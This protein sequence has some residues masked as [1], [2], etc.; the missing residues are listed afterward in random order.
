MD[1][2]LHWWIELEVDEKTCIRTILENSGYYELIRK[3]YNNTNRIRKNKMV[4]EIYRLYSDCYEHY[5]SY[6]TIMDSIE[7]FM[8]KKNCSFEDAVNSN[9]FDIRRF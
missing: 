2:K 5:Y 8:N 7:D 9:E 6:Y 3:E 4:D 1:W